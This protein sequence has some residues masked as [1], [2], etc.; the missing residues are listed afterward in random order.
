MTN[1]TTAIKTARTQVSHL[2]PRSGQWYVQ[3]YCKIGKGWFESHQTSYAKAQAMRSESLIN[4]TLINLGM[5]LEAADYF[6]QK[7]D[8]GPWVEFVRKY[9]KKMR[10]EAAFRARF[11]EI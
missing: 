8:G 9:A 10:Q 7:Y 2:L 5:T 6:T 4:K 3:T 11:Q 1:L